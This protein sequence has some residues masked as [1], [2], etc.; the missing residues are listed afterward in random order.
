MVVVDVALSW[1][2]SVACV[3][4]VFVMVAA[5]VAVFQQWPAEEMGLCGM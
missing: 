5:A 3:V 4:S 1:L 2:A